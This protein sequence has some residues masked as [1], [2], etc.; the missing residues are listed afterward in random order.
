MSLDEQ[1]LVNGFMADC[2]SLS[3][4][5]KSTTRRLAICSG[6]QAHAHCRS[7]S[8]PVSAPLPRTPRALGP[9]CRNWY[10]R[11]RRA[12]LPHRIA[13][14]CSRQASLP[15]GD[16]LTALRAIGQRLRGNPEHRCA[17]SHCVGP[18]VISSRRNDQADVRSPAGYDPEQAAAR[19]LRAL[20]MTDIFP[21]ETSP[22]GLNIAGGIP[23]AS[24]NHLVPTGLRHPSLER[25]RLTAHA[26]PCRDQ[27]PE[28]LAL[29]T[30]GHRWPAGRPQ[31]RPTTS[32]RPP[33]PSAHR[34]LLLQD[35][36]TTD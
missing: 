17:L 15:W 16:E 26:Y 2:A 21:T 28:R 13:R 23:P 30:R 7:W 8:W 11:H 33:L 14:R 32:I 3:S 35:V 5:G 1:R 20:G 9:G 29:A 12:S 24:R 31:W 25:S 10:A 36:A 34:N 6:L 22:V 18:H 4:S 19:S 27:C